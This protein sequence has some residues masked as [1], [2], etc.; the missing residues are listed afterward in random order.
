M[1]MVHETSVGL[2]VVVLVCGL[3]GLLLPSYC[4]LFKVSGILIPRS[5]I[6]HS[7][8]VS[9]TRSYDITFVSQNGM[10]DGIGSLLSVPSFS[11]WGL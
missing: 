7:W 9:I 11:S 5:V 4:M 1:D 3:L 10:L 2:V 8:A 6:N